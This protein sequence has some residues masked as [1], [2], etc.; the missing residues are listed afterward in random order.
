MPARGQTSTKALV[1]HLEQTETSQKPAT[2]GSNQTLNKN[3]AKNPKKT[4]NKHHQGSDWS[5]SRGQPNPEEHQIG[6][7]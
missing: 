4:C 1:D 7:G 3:P 2:T 5:T 6:T